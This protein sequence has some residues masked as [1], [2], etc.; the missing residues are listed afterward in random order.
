MLTV[1]PVDI[2]KEPRMTRMAADIFRT[3]D[4]VSSGGPHA[5]GIPRGLP[6]FLR[7]VFVF[8]ETILADIAA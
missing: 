6:D 3:S 2:V 7:S 5:D 1:H 8:A 4:D